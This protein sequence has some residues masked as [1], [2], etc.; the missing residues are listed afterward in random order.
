MPA[1]VKT[2]TRSVGAMDIFVMVFFPAKLGIEVRG[3]PPISQSARNGWG[4]ETY[5]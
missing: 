2:K 1:P 4:T 5:S 3:I